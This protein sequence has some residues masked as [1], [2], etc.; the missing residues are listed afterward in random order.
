[1]Q[2]SL[3]T[4]AEPWGARAESLPGG[5]VKILDGISSANAYGKGIVQKLT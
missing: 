5:D 2:L 4:S 3:A 1:M